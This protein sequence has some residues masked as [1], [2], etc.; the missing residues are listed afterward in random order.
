[1]VKWTILGGIVVLVALEVVALLVVGG[2][3]G[4]AWT[5]AWMAGSCVAGI[6]IVRVAGLSTL[7]RIH[8]QLTAE[9]IPTR[10]LMDMALILLGALCL[11]LPGFVTDAA[12]ILLVLP[13]VR[14][15]LRWGLCWAYREILPQPYPPGRGMG[16]VGEVIDVRPEE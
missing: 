4:V 9:I 3:L 11:I 12:G 8:R 10:E 15:A 7:I 6:V 13:P 1:M 2:R 14:W 5:L 16:R